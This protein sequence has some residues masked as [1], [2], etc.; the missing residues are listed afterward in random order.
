MTRDQLAQKRQ[1]KYCPLNTKEKLPDAKALPAR[2]VEGIFDVLK[3]TSFLFGRQRREPQ[4]TVVATDDRRRRQ[5]EI[6]AR[7]AK[8][9]RPK[10]CCKITQPTKTKQASA[11]M[12]A[13]LVHRPWKSHC[14]VTI[15]QARKATGSAKGTSTGLRRNNGQTSPVFSRMNATVQM[16]AASMAYSM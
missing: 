5:S 8:R 1:R 11:V 7:F 12:R 15:S 16:S 4:P 9:L 10:L 13:P 2:I 3:N 14:S 6:G